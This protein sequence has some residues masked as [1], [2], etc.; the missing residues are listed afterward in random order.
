M[1]PSARAMM[2]QTLC[3]YYGPSR[4]VQK[5]NKLEVRAVKKSYEKT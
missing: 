5:R 2:I 3:R 4:A 1:Y